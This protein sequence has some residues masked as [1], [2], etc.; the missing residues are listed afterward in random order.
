[1]KILALG[2]GLAK[3]PGP[4][5]MDRSPVIVGAEPYRFRGGAHV[6]R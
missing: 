3:G 6:P 4:V 1:M 5:G 2:C